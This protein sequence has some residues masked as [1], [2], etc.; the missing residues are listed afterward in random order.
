MHQSVDIFRD[1]VHTNQNL[2]PLLNGWT[3]TFELHTVDTNEIF[4]FS[5]SNLSVT[6]L[7]TGEAKDN[8]NKIT[9]KGNK[10]TICDALQGK[11]SLTGL[12]IDNEIDISASNLNTV[13]LD[14][15]YLTV[16]GYRD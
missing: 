8:T 5:L 7:A 9:I 16:W 10:T 12:K 2:K 6:P 3:A 11:R 1:N 4:H 14:A 13:K 15:I